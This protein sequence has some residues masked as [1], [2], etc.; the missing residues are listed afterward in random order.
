MLCEDTKEN[1]PISD[2]NP[3]PIVEEKKVDNLNIQLEIENESNGNQMLSDEIQN[4]IN[5][6]LKDC[7]EHQ[8]KEEEMSKEVSDPQVN[9]ETNAES[10]V[11]EVKDNNHWNYYIVIDRCRKKVC[12]QFLIKL[13]RIPKSRIKTLQK[14][15]LSGKF[16][17]FSCVTKIKKGLLNFPSSIL[18]RIG[19]I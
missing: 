13:F 8:Q 6:S 16:E 14:K 4:A 1:N 9:L 3:A 18:E 10:E 15:I 7:L 12:L 11:V 17:M 19:N 5:E 2:E